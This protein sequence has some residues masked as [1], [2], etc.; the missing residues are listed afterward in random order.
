MS[1]EVGVKKRGRPKKVI[2]DLVE[3]E[4]PELKK[5]TRAKSTKAAPKPTKTPS[6]TSAK[7]IAPK[8]SVAKPITASA[9]PKTIPKSSASPKPV[10]KA[11]PPQP[12]SVAPEEKPMVKAE[13][14]PSKILEQVRELEAR[15]TA[16]GQE[17]QATVPVADSKS[18]ATAKPTSTPPSNSPAANSKP[19]AEVKTPNAK[20][21]PSNPSAAPPPP[22]KPTS[23]PHIPL[24]AL[25]SDIVSNISARA[26]A[27]PNKSGNNPLPKNYKSVSNKVTM[28]LVALPIAICTSYVLWQRCKSSLCLCNRFT[29]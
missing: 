18:V 16:S 17:A 23:K 24:A 22:P 12:K 25:N 21:M 26:G 4:I 29:S 7:A 27:R 11:A 28:V 3:V 13:A 2:P 1:A 19:I 20:S 5:T 6:T 14:P 8:K 10:S 9:E 15:R